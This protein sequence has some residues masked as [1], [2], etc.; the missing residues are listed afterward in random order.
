MVDAVEQ[1][2]F[3]ESLFGDV[4]LLVVVAE[5]AVRHIVFVCVYIEAIDCLLEECPLFVAI[6]VRFPSVQN[7]WIQFVVHGYCDAFVAS[8][9]KD[10]QQQKGEYVGSYS[11]FHDISSHSRQI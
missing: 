10:G 5:I 1:P 11:L 2:V 9:K 4:P 6:V 8:P 3:I 7:S